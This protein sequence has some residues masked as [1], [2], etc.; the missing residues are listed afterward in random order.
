MPRFR[1]RNRITPMLIQT[2]LRAGQLGKALKPVRHGLAIETRVLVS[3]DG[4]PVSVRIIRPQG[5]AKGLVLDFHGGGWVIGNAQ[6]N[7]DVNIA[8]VQ[9]CDVAVIS[10]DYR[11][12][13]ST[14]LQGLL[15][16]CLAATRC[17][18][19]GG[20]PEFEDLPV[21]MVGESAGGHLA[22]STLLQ[23]KRW[24]ALLQRVCGALLYYGVFDLTGTPSVRNA[25]PETL[26]LDG[27]GMLEA[28]RRLTPGLEDE[29]RRQPSL[30]PLYG[31]LDGLPPALMFAGELDPLRDD[32][33]L[34]AERW[35]RVA[36]V[37]LC[38]LPASPH[39]FIHFPTPM[40]D[41]ALA[42]SREWIVRRL[43]AHAAQAPAR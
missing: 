27:P 4:V 15:D 23:L 24:P 5:P 1:I 41:K 39:G 8:L 40:A 10:V 35:G 25:G 26:V 34:M 21:I 14:P 13:V 42:H 28:F 29:Q 20:F 6:M 12:A 7:D 37:D 17:V 16:D 11:L 3:P 36:T 18:L 32:T 19:G 22:A 30:S 43:S 33:L 38:L 9:A 31:D 2:L